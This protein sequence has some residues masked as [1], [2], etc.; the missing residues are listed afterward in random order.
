VLEG[1]LGGGHGAL[2]G[3]GV[4]FRGI[5]EFKLHAFRWFWI[6]LSIFG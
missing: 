4:G 5:K 3:G 2:K 1:G 6:F